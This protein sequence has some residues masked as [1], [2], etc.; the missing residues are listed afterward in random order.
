[1]EVQDDGSVIYTALL[2]PDPNRQNF[3]ITSERAEIVR[4]GTG[5]AWGGFH[6]GKKF[7]MSVN[8]KA[9][10]ENI[11]HVDFYIDDGFFAKQYLQFDAN[12]K[13]ITDNI[14]ILYIGESNAIGSY[15]LEY[16]IIGGKLTLSKDSFTDDLLIFLGR[17]DTNW[18]ERIDLLA[19]P[20]T[21][22][23]VA[24]FN[25]GKTQEETLVFNFKE[26]GKETG[27]IGMIVRHFSDEELLQ[28]TYDATDMDK[29]ELA[30]I[31]EAQ[32]QNIGEV[33]VSNIDVHNFVRP[34]WAGYWMITFDLLPEGSTEWLLNQT[35]VVQQMST[36]PVTRD[37][38]VRFIH[39]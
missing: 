34:T 9:E 4:T 22:R 20:F 37:I 35:Q 27:G 1:M 16:E 30:F 12:G 18:G 25:D 14:P 32:N 38:V 13:L 11:K 29:M 10:G 2:S 15:G 21:V 24:T 17:E 6:D 23:A 8:L 31:N 26:M 33:R 36:D 28:M 5:L 19:V 7:L 3:D 39:E